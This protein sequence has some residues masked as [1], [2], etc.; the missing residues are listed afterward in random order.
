MTQCF[1]A[2]VQGR[3]SRVCTGC[4]PCDFRDFTML[5]FRP[6]ECGD[7]VARM[8]DMKADCLCFSGEWL[9]MSLE[10]SQPWQAKFPFFRYAVK[11]SL[12]LSL[13]EKAVVDHCLCNIKEELEWGVDDFSNGLLALRIHILLSESL[14]FYKRQFITRSC[15]NKCLMGKIERMVDEYV[16]SGEYD[17]CR[18]CSSASRFA[19]QMEMSEAFFVDF[20]KLETGKT[21]SQYLCFRHFEVAKRMLRSSSDTL[22]CVSR[23]LG[24]SSVS[25][26]SLAFKRVVGCSPSEYK[27]AN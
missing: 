10:L 19:S 17:I 15:I 11:E 13:R 24:Y 3:E 2:V 9:D 20:L 18:T 21:F 22:T 23:R 8:K 1:V 25:C 26:F 12:H 27:N 16:A 5:F 6:G 4:T 14:R 7:Y